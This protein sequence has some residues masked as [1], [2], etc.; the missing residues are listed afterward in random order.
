M[1]TRPRR[2]LTIEEI[3]GQQRAVGLRVTAQ[4]VAVM[5]QLQRAPAPMTHAELAV[6]LEPRGWDRATTYRNLTDL[7]EA[8]LLRRADIGD[9]VWRFE[10]Q[11]ESEADDHVGAGHPHFV[12]G[13]CGDVV[14]LPPGA[15]RVAGGRGLPKALEAGAVEIQFK[16]RCDR[17]G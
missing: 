7:T 15:V 12:C 10:L 5:E 8:G 14:C 16:G 6:A 1:A 2:D 17:C 4:R 13:A 3:R 9:H 11:R